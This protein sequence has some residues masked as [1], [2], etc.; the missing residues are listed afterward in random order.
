MK[1]ANYKDDEDCTLKKESL[2]EGLVKERLG[3][4][5]LKERL[6]T[7]EREWTLKK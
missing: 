7:K 2:R 4:E 5:R 1:R 3:T 6:S